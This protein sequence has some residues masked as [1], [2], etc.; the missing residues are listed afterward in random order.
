M[1]VVIDNVATKT[2]TTFTN[3]DAWPQ[4][5]E[6]MEG[7]DKEFLKKCHHFIPIVV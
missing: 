3:P 4:E 2:S 7:I 1:S 5:G 6:D